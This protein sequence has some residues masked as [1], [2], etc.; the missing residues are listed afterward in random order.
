[1]RRII[2]DKGKIFGKINIIDFLVFLVVFCLMPIFYF[3]YKIMTK[4]PE[5]IEKPPPPPHFYSIK[6][7][8][9]NCKETISIDIPKRMAISDMWYAEE[10]C[11]NCG[12]GFAWIDTKG[13]KNARAKR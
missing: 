2:D 8:C 1:M 6:R 10:T 7:T 4:E 12:C 3:G 5:L 9:P 13:Y 11:P